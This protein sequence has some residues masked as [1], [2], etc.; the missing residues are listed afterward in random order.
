MEKLLEE[1]RDAI[2]SIDEMEDEMEFFP[3]ADK[4]FDKIKTLP[5]SIEAVGKVL[6]IIEENDDKEYG[7]PGPI[8]HFLESFYGNKYEELLV[9]SLKRAPKGYTI[10]LLHRCINDEKNEK[11]NEYKQLIKAI[12]ED[13]N[14]SEEVREEARFSLECFE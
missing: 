3:I 14:I 2:S 11:R 1:L 5:N 8:G 4:I 7:G 12:A 9:E 13:A 10:F 6:K